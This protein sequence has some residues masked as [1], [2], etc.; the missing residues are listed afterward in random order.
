MFYVTNL[1]CKV[2]WV[3]VVK[4]KTYNSCT[5]ELIEDLDIDPDIPKDVLRRRLPDGMTNIKT[6]F[7]YGVLPNIKGTNGGN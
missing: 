1:R 7:E 6:I 5:G 3:H 2:E 4:R